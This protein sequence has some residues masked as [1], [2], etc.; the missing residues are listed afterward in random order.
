M[1]SF[2]DAKVGRVQHVSHSLSSGKR[3]AAKESTSELSASVSISS[4]RDDLDPSEGRPLG[5]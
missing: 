4:G 5:I 1:S 3:E 2:S